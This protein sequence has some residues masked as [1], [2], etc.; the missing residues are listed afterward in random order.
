MTGML[1]VYL[2]STAS[3]WAANP[4][5]QLLYQLG[6]LFETTEAQAIPRGER[7]P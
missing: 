3:A 5:P 7:E 6:C 1:F 4:S 2:L